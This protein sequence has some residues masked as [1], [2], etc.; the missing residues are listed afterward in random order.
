MARIHSRKKGK[1]SS[2]RPYRA[3]PPEWVAPKPKEVERTVIRLADEGLSTSLIGM[4]MRDQYGVPSV[5]LCTGKSITTIL[6]EHKRAPKLP[7][8]LRNLMR[9]A[10]NIGE[11]LVE[12]PKDKHN[13]R[14]LSLT[15]AKIRRLIRYYK[16]EGVLEK[17]WT[18]KLSTAK[19]LVE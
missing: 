17:E 16:S 3:E 14:A 9:K 8:D 4:K 1:S 19:L 11:H 13:Q 6:S 10:V 2:N 7:E 12:N 18:Y 15:E 5:K